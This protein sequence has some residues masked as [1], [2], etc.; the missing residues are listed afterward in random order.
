MLFSVL[1]NKLNVH[2]AEAAGRRRFVKDCSDEY[3]RF[4]IGVERDQC[5][6]EVDCPIVLNS[7]VAQ[8]KNFQRGVLLQKLGKCL[9]AVPR[10]A[11]A[12]SNIMPQIRQI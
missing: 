11:I 6:A 3:P 2:F 4:E 5:L 9:G 1:A 12:V 7:V 10:D 8:V